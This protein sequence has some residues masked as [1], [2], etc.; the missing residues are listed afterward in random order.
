MN[1]ILVSIIIPIYKT[2]WSELEQC[3]SSVLSQTYRNLDII[4]VD[5]GN[6]PE[7][8]KSWKDFY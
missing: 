4:M 2:K 6:D 5:D 7:Y 8:A 3:I 1:T